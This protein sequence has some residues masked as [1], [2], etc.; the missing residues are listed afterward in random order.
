MDITD[1]QNRALAKLKAFQTN[2]PSFWDE[3]EVSQFN[4]VVSELNEAF[5]V[6]LSSFLIPATELKP[7]DDGSGSTA[8]VDAGRHGGRFSTAGNQISEKRCCDAKF[9]Q[10]K[11]DQLVNYSQ[12][13][14][15]PPPEPPK[16]GF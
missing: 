9:A 16:I 14:L 4:E 6:D 12:N 15:Q 13:L 11:L 3:S 1:K 2:P 5:E 7:Y 10:R 8:W